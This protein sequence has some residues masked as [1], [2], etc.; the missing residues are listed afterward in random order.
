ML[1]HSVIYTTLH[2]LLFPQILTFFENRE[3]GPTLYT[4]PDIRSC[5]MA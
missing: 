4:Y 2:A 5:V 1:L 3:T